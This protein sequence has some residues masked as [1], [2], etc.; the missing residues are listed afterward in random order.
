[1]DLYT[2]R[3]MV[4][5]FL[6]IPTYQRKGYGNMLSEVLIL[7][8]QT[9]YNYF[10]NEKDCLEITTEDPGSEFIL[11]REITLFKNMINAGKFD[12][13]LNSFL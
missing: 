1:M 8:I 6:I 13:L 10:I 3:A 5:Q 2:Y 9:I 12:N 7:L 4:S 11:L